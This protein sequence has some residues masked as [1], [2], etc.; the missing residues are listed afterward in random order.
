[1]LNIIRSDLFRLGK[2]KIW[3]ICFILFA[4]LITVPGIY[5]LSFL[6][7][8]SMDTQI[9]EVG[10]YR[11]ARCAE[12]GIEPYELTTEQNRE[13]SLELDWFK[14]D[15]TVIGGNYF[16]LYVVTILYIVLITTRDFSSHSLK[17]TLSAPI[18]RKTYF[19]S[20]LL[21]TVI[22]SVSSLVILNLFTWI[23]NLIIN[24]SGHALTFG[25]MLFATIKQILPL[26]AFI[27]IF[28]L[29]AFLIRKSL[30][31][32]LASLGIFF[33]AVTILI[34]ISLM[35]GLKPKF[36]I[37]FPSFVFGGVIFTDAEDYGIY[38]VVSTIVCVTLIAV[39]NLLGYL[40]FK[41]Q[42][43]K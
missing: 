13:I 40:S 12:M 17:N 9:Y 7:N 31:Y 15:L 18:A 25:A 4:V 8:S 34:N 29:L 33:F 6:S 22:M 3:F 37:Y 24:G 10:D 1:M 5:S 42:E 30:P 20:K 21:T 19:F 28:N 11:E 39:T 27:S 38:M 14:P 43:I 2:A 32:A 36:M 35:F 23:L 16:V 41:K 26:V